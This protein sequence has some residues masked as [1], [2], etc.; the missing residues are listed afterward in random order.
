[1]QFSILVVD[2]DPANIRVLSTLL[3]SEYKVF[4]AKSGQSAVDIAQQ[5][6][7]NL[8]LLD[9]VMP[10]MDGFDV[11]K[12]LKASPK[13]QDIPVIFVTGLNSENHEE[14]GLKLGASDYIHKPFHSGIVKARIKNQLDILRRNHL[15][16]K[17]AHIDVLTELPNRRKWQKDLNRYQV[18]ANDKNNNLAIG[19]LDVDHF[20]EYNDYYGH[21]LGDQTL[22]KLAQA[23]NKEMSKYGAELYRFGGE[24]FVFI[25]FNQDVTLIEQCIAKICNTVE[26]E[27][28]EHKASKVKPVV[29]ISG[30]ACIQSCNDEVS[31]SRMLELADELLYKVKQQGKNHIQLSHT[32]SIEQRTHNGI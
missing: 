1:M 20:K 6:L 3:K 17:V 22:L 18:L 10:D 26:Q 11:L 8:I 25:L 13:T 30:G 15:L 12:Q 2:D 14:Y 31:S 9:I 23:I 29:T 24:E 5:H 28:I 16:E 4:V 32:R 21:S 19:I 27:Q 7:P